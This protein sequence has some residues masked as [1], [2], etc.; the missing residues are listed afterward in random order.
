MDVNTGPRLPTP[1]YRLPVEGEAEIW[2]KDDGLTHPEYGGNKVR[3]LDGLLAEAAAR[4]ARRVVTVGAVGSHH[5]LATTLFAARLGIRTTAG[6][7]PQ[8]ADRHVEQTIRAAMGLG[9]R[10]LPA[11]S[12]A[13]AAL[14][15]LATVRAG[16]FVVAPGGSSPA[17]CM[18]YVTAARELEGQVRAGLFPEPDL[19][20]VPFGS[21]GTAAGLVAGLVT[22]SLA[23]RVV[24][25]KVVDSVLSGAPLIASLAMA[26]ARRSGS[27]ASWRDLVRRVVVDDSE[28]GAGYGEPTERAAAAA[29]LA[30][31]H[32]LDLDA[33][34]TAKAFALI[35]ALAGADAALPR[36]PKTSKSRALS[37][38]IRPSRLLY[39]HTLS[40]APLGP[41]LEGAPAPD[42]LP[43]PVRRLLGHR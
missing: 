20:V 37:A 9:L 10:P 35:L 36:V 17:G 30:A 14:L 11:A 15:A 34:Y 18:G 21:G 33:T 43:A 27:A 5:V 8:R 39:W 42:E 3:K 38:R 7:F 41:L 25:A 4:G 40:R 2:V 13:G 12:R 32:D 28:L 6:L 29:A 1:V 23:T 31:R 22:T 19:I 16:D 24:A 26:T